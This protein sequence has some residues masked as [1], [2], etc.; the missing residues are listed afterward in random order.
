[1]WTKED[2]KSPVI[3]YQI[4]KKWG[5]VG[6]KDKVSYYQKGKYKSILGFDFPQNPENDKMKWRGSGILF[7]L[8]SNWKIEYFHEGHQWMLISFSK[9]LFTPGGY[10]VLTKKENPDLNVVS[11]IEE[12]LEEHQIND[13]VQL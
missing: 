5:R 4:D 10:D 1:M 2:K 7:F 6:L 12:Y 3:K 9:S 11:E 8:T 13:L